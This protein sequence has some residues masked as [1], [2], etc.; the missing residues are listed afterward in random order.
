MAELLSVIVA[1]VRRGAAINS[2]AVLP[3][4][5]AGSGVLI[6]RAAPASTREEAAAPDA[7]APWQKRWGDVPQ[8]A[9]P[10]GAVPF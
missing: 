10:W 3:R 8:A 4:S 2:E 7:G 6:V 9:S 1:L 5:A